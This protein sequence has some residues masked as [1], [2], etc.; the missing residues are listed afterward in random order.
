[1]VQAASL[2]SVPVA[3][4]ALGSFAATRVPPSRRVLSG[5]QHFAAGVVIAALAGELLPGLRSEGNLGWVVV[6]FASGVTLVMSLAAYS[7]RTDELQA[8]TSGDL[9]RTLLTAVP[10]GFLATVAIDLLVDG[11]LV[12]L[13]TQLGSRQ[14]VILTVALTLEILFLCLA[15]VGDLTD[16]GVPSRMAATIC[17]GLSL[18][19][20]VGAITAAAFLGDASIEAL[21][22]LLAF[23]AAALLYLAVEE[24][25]V[26]AHE[27]SE[28]AL[29]GVMFFVGFLAIYVLGELGG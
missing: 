4:G 2:V 18:F 9:P 11:L 16:R 3:A 17:A 7:R 22:A 15:L 13:G 21:A 27:E 10:V 23:G 24:L 20:A 6:G 25:L 26:E 12:G 19:T 8:T 29:L 1:V 14:A 5:I 28:T